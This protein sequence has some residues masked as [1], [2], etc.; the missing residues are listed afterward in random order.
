[1][2]KDKYRTVF[3]VHTNIQISTQWQQPHIDYN[4]IAVVH[5]ALLISNVKVHK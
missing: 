5:K 2:I 4:P 1:M 3:S